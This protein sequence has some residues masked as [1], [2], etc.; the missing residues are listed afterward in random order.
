MHAIQNTIENRIN[1]MPHNGIG[2]NKKIPIL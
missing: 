1:E 2:N